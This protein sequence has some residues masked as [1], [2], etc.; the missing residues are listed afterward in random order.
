[1]V[2]S[3][4]H[5]YVFIEI[6]LT[7]SWA[8]RNEL[9]QHYGGKPILHKHATYSEF[10]RWAGGKGREYFVFGTVR[11][12]L[13]EL[14]SRYLKIKNDHKGVFTNAEALRAKRVE[15]ADLRQFAFIRETDAS[16]ADYFGRYRRRTFG[17]FLDL[18]S[19][20]MTFVMRFERLQQDFAAVLET[21]GMEQVRQVPVANATIG[22]NGDWTCY[23]TPEVIDQAKRTCAPF[24][25]RWGYEFPPEWGTYEPSRREN[26]GYGL[27]VWLR[28]IYAENIRYQDNPLASA[29]RWLR[30]RLV[31]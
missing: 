28:K 29:A 24:M 31:R 3:P 15:D 6:P 12:P 2:V 7:G 16:F 25:S 17:S 23:Y 27:S 10:N 9:C 30:A 11:H 20:F 18:S 13:D 26:L 4:E 5:R 8:I 14:V 22:K 19:E 21:L 1:M